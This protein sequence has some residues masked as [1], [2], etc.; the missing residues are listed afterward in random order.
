MKKVSFCCVN[1]GRVWPGCSDASLLDTLDFDIDPPTS[2]DELAV[3]M[4]DA[5][6]FAADDNM[7]VV[8]EIEDEEAAEKQFQG[9]AKVVFQKWLLTLSLPTEGTILRCN[10]LYMWY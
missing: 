1:L 3:T 5:A 7:V 4:E 6:L 2:Q 9:Y 8:N 10:V